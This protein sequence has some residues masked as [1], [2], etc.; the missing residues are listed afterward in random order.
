[1][2]EPSESIPVPPLAP[3]APD[4]PYGQPAD[5][6]P[7][8]AYP[9]G[10]GYPPNQAYTPYQSY[11]YPYPMTPAPVRELPKGQAITGMVLG[12]VGLC[13]ALFYIGGV[14]GIIGLVF[15]IL[16][17]RKTARREGAGRG[18]AIAGLVT[19]VIAII[20]NAI[21]IILIVWFV[22]TVSNCDQYSPSLHPETGSQTQFDNCVRQGI[23]GS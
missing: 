8:A 12:I 10:A 17:I 7:P 16:A 1:L 20:L 3:P 19:S 14:I 6:P 13:T 15:S 9:A 5:A 2:S 18:M 22:H 23:L 21:E 4:G 11:G